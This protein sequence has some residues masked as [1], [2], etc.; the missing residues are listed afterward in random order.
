MAA[1]CTYGGAAGS[2]RKDPPQRW[3][4]GAAR[5]ATATE[6]RESQAGG[7]GARHVRRPTGTERSSPGD[8][9]GTSARG[10]R[11]A[12]TA[13]GSVEPGLVCLR[14]RRQRWQARFCEGVDSSALDSLA[15]RAVQVRE[16]EEAEELRG[17]CHGRGPVGGGTRPA[18]TRRVSASLVIPLSSGASRLSLVPGMA[19]KREEEEEEEEE[20]DQ[21]DQEDEVFY[22]RLCCS[23]FGFQANIV[24]EPVLFSAF[25]SRGERAIVRQC[26]LRCFPL[27]GILVGMD[28]KVSVA[29]GRGRARRRYGSGMT[30][31]GMLVM[32]LSLLC[33]LLC[34][35]VQ[36]LRIMARMDQK[37]RSQRH[38]WDYS[39]RFLLGM[40]RIQRNAWFDSGYIFASVFEG[41]GIPRIF[42]VEVDLGSWGRFRVCR[43]LF[44]GFHKFS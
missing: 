23:G 7:R 10:R 17:A 26:L 35:Q 34:R 18:S 15:A 2:R 27:L 1:A 33:F 13:R 40:F 3:A 4:G 30:I 41:L 21:E 12:G 28:Q 14:L 9:A 44:D 16:E 24:E 43:R 5:R 38:S 31:S 42:C 36:M 19:Q 6:E 32:L 22:V 25:Y 39:G 11:A 8:A 29:V 37:D 20:E